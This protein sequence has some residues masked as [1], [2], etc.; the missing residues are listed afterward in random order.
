MK[1]K[2]YSFV[3][4]FHFDYLA[5]YS[6][7]SRYCTRCTLYCLPKLLSLFE[8]GDGVASCIYFCCVSSYSFSIQTQK[9]REN[10]K[11]MNGIPS[12]DGDERAK[13]EI[14]FKKTDALI[15]LLDFLF[16][17][18]FAFLVRC[19]IRNMSG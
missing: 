11:R 10:E 15:C 19:H 2:N 14:K 9:E 18:Y 4:F 13:R 5:C 6:S 16:V 17:D 7:Y 3:E 8:W 1:K 12:V